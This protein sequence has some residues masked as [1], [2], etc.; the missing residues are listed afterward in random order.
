MAYDIDELQNDIAQVQHDDA[1]FGTGRLIAE[2][3][4]LTTA[5]LLWDE[6]KGTGP[7][8]DGWQVRLERDRHRNMWVFRRGNRVIWH[9]RI[10]DLALILLVNP[11]GGPFRPELR[12]RIAALL[13]SNPH[14]VE[15]RG[16]PRASK[17]AQGP[18]ALTP[19][20][21][22]LTAGDRGHPLRFGVDASDF[23]H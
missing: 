4:I 10:L 19:A 16:Y 7:V 1:G 21:G 23:T 14:P 18:R 6:V 22:R 12:L 15:A 2:D 17:E 8:L 3:L 9:D 13:L 5:H 20:F 11:E